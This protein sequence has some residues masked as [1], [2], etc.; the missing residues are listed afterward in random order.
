M[1]ERA[2]IL[3]EWESG[4][5]PAAAA[6]ARLL[7]VHR[8][9]DDLRLGLAGSPLLAVLD[10]HE[11]GVLQTLAVLDLAE[12]TPVA[13]LEGCRRLFDGAASLNAAAGV[14]VYCLG[15]EDLLAAATAETVEL[16]ARLGVG[17]AGQRILDIGCGTGRFEAALAGRVAA[18]TGIDLSAGMLRA[19]HERCRSLGNVELHQCDGADLRAFADASFDAVIAV[20]SFP[21][22]YQ[23][24]GPALAARHLREAARVLRDTGEIVVLNLSYRNDPARDVED[25][26]E[27][28]VATALALKRAGTS[29]LRSW[30]GRT[31]HFHKDRPRSG[32]STAPQA[33]L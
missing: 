22:L 13:D 20:D 17:R 15:E 4:A 7:M 24:G 29:D 9:V 6:L 2:T 11:P 31:F 26:A 16:L 30:D 3:A 33:Y 21:Y 8:D 10:R 18:I 5:I 12:R 32:R 14:A 28:A 19:A 23:A 27:M 1:A 25:A